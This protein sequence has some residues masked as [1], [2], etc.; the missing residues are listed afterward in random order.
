MKKTNYVEQE[1]IRIITDSK[2]N[3]HKFGVMYDY[4]LSNKDIGKVAAALTDFGMKVKIVL[5]DDYKAKI[6]ITHII[7]K[8]EIPDFIISGLNKVLKKKLIKEFNDFKD[9][10]EEKDVHYKI[11]NSLIFNHY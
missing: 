5:L 9:S 1:V 4:E 8:T 6:S 11:V 3:N 2:R 7:P 10:S